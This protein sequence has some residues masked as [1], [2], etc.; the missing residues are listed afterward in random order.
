[1][2]NLDAQFI[3]VLSNGQH[4]ARIPK[5]ARYQTFHIWKTIDGS[6]ECPLNNTGQPG[7]SPSLQFT[8]AGFAI[9]VTSL[10]CRMSRGGSQKSLD[11]M[12]T[13]KKKVSWMDQVTCEIQIFTKF[14][15]HIL[16]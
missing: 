13:E 16:S 2:L 9:T 14:D 12:N 6:T 4:S 7:S 5:L 10:R 15:I 11:P 3:I 8:A 1:M